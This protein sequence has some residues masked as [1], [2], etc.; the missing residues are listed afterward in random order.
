MQIQRKH[1]GSAALRIAGRLI[2]HRRC[3][4]L[5]S[6]Y[7]NY[8]SGFCCVYTDGTALFNIARLSYGLAPAFSS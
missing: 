5:R 3:N 4:L 2:F 8:G 7:Y 6:P 1:N